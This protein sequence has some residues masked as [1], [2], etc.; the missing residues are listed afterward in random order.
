M[1]GGQ[2]EGK[3]FRDEDINP[4]SC[5]HDQCHHP[6]LHGLLDS[7]SGKVA[8]LPGGVALI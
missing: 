4:C 3:A 7:F 2:E 5:L 1:K 8:A 6:K